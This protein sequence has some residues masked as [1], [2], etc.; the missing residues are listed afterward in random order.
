MRD[1]MPA[2]GSA[3]PRLQ[4]RGR[5]CGTKGPPF[6]LFL[7][8]RNKSHRLGA[9]AEAPFD[10]PPRRASRRT[11]FAAEERRRSGGCDCVFRTTTSGVTAENLMDPVALS[12]HGKLVD[13]LTAADEQEELGA[14]GARLQPRVDKSLLCPIRR[15]FW[16]IGI[17]GKQKSAVSL[18]GRK[19]ARIVLLACRYQEERRQPS[20]RRR[21][22]L[23]GLSGD[24]G[25]PPWVAH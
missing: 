21:P 11:R 1:A 5:R 18:V 20:P 22:D 19:Q 17:A 9:A 15:V 4:P 12:R 23:R 3:G 2:S 6:G 13:L 7:R 14:S 25:G 10:S 24:Y 8:Y 16:D